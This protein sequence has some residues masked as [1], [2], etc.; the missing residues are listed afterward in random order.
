M[1]LWCFVCMRW[2]SQDAPNKSGCQEAD[3]GCAV[4]RNESGSAAIRV[5]II[6]SIVAKSVGGRI[7]NAL[8][9]LLA[10]YC[11]TL[12]EAQRLRGETVWYVAHVSETL[13]VLTFCA[14]ACTILECVNTIRHSRRR[15]GGIDANI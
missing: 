9:R 3:T 12:A 1:P 6:W 15:P 11:L 4:V 13:F 8:Y 10:V 7:T 2:F 14:D 5:Y